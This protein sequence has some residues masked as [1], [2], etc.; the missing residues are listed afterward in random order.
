MNILFL[1]YYIFVRLIL[2]KPKV[3]TIC[4]KK[5]KFYKFKSLTYETRC[6]L[7]K[8]Y[9]RTIIRKYQLYLNPYLGNDHTNNTT[10]TNLRGNYPQKSKIVFY[11]G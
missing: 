5:F 2:R 8:K 3:Y 4:H 6:V 10:V 7:E 1:K 9:F 11:E